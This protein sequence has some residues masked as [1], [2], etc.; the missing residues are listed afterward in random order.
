MNDFKEPKDDREG[1][2]DEQRDD[3]IRKDLDDI[4]GKISESEGASEPSAAPEQPAAPQ[5][6]SESIKAAKP[7]EAEGLDNIL[8][9]ISEKEEE[10][11]EE[12]SIFHRIVGIFVNPTKVFTYLRAKPEYLVPVILTILISI[13]TSFFVYDIAIDDQVKR[14]E[15]S[16]KFTEEQ[17]DMIIDK[18]EDSRSGTKRILYTYVVPAI[19]VLII[20]TL[21]SAI[22]L[23][24][25]NI[26]L[27]GKAR[28]VQVFSAYAYAYLILAIVGT[29]VKLPLWISQHTMKV[30]T[31][32]AVFLPAS[33]EH[34]ALYRFIASFDVFTVW[35]LIVFGIGFAIIYRFS[36]LKGILAVVI[37][38]LVYV[39]LFKVALGGFLGAI[40][41]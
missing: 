7:E 9:K 34:T 29:A 17:R 13:T 39:A 15:Q 35:F 2:N 3:D 16:E 20:F 23:F 25:G 40:G 1:N 22:F 30:D 18:I 4:L 8:E 19:S 24:V 28:F 33:I 14:F 36:Q 21:V 32:P 37:S 11:V 12:L 38:W 26:M 6:P 10:P 41:S 27:G 31:S 5:E